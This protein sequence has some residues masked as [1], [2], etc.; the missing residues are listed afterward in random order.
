MLDLRNNLY[1]YEV[2]SYKLITAGKK[3]L[4]VQVLKDV[5]GG[6]PAKYIAS[7]LSD[8]NDIARAKQEY[9]GKGESE[10]QALQDCI[11]KIADCDLQAILNSTG[12]E[13]S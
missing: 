6:A 12:T 13:H 4:S 2:K 1:L 5:T 10:E 3:L 8:K 9:V 11:D 7:P